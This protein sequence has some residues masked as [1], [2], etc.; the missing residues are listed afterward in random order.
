MQPI[1]SMKYQATNF[2]RIS[3]VLKGKLFYIFSE[4]NMQFYSEQQSIQ[5]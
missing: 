5:M 3:F 4:Y 2:Q 1:S